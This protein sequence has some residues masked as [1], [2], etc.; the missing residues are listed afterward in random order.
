L[1]P[2][3]DVRNAGAAWTAV[4]MLEVYEDEVEGVCTH[5]QSARVCVLAR[6]LTRRDYILFEAI[7]EFGDVAAAGPA[8]ARMVAAD[9]GWR[10]NMQDTAAAA[11]DIAQATETTAKVKGGI[12]VL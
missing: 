1:L 5:A 6:K 4:G 10:K 11:T 12:L 9:C 7:C 8:C 3:D 2:E